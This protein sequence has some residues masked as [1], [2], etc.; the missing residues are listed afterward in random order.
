MKEKSKS[1]QMLHL[2][3]SIDATKKEVWHTM[4]DDKTYRIWA[5]IFS[6]GS[7][8]KGSW[9]KG[10]KI[11]FLGPDDMGIFSRIEENRPYEFISI[12]HLGYIKDGKEDLKSKG[13]KAIAGAYENYTLKEKNGITELSVDVDTNEEYKEMFEDLWPK[14]LLKLK[15]LAERNSQ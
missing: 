7:H 1:M 9:E 15:E 14:A 8:F 11:H 12:Q 4:L 10:S 3:I 13:A 2:S 5:D 6:K